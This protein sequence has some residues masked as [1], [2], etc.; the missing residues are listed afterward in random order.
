[1]RCPII[2]LL[3]V[4]TH[5]LEPDLIPEDANNEDHSV[6]VADP[7]PPDTLLINAAKGAILAHSLLEISVEFYPRWALSQYDSYI[8]YKVSYHKNS[9][10]QSLSL[11]EKGANGGGA[12]TEVRVI[13]KTGRT[14]DIRGIDNHPCTNI[15]IGIGTVG[16][17]IQ[18]QK[19][20]I[21]GIMHQYSLLNKGSTIH[22]PCQ[23]EWYKNEVNDKSINVP[24]G[25]QWM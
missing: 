4:Y 25:L 7:E 13:F 8:E 24:G 6:D 15:D 5:R 20:P 12:G 16:G 21:F 18:T 17:V 2:R 3:Q 19:S 11:M 9:S 1:M 10:G 22:Y 23:L 14:I